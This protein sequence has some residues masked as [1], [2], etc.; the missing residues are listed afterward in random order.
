MKDF[1][2]LMKL[3]LPELHPKFTFDVQWNGVNLIAAD[4]AIGRLMFVEGTSEE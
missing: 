1:S 2:S 3:E 4:F